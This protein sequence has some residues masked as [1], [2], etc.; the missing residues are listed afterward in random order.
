MSWPF[1]NRSVMLYF[2]YIVHH[3]IHQPLRIDLALSSV[4]ESVEPII[5][6][7]VA[8]HRLNGT[9]SLAVYVPA[10]VAVDLLL[11]LLEQVRLRVRAFTAPDGHLPS[12]LRRRLAHT[13]LL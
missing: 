12:A 2:L 5:G 13:A 4:T 3:A 9:D 8:E 10:S 1:I 6:V 7:D 11:H